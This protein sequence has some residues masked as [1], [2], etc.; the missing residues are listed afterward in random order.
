MACRW[1]AAEGGD[2]NMLRY[3]LEDA[4]R[5]GRACY[6][7]DAVDKR[8]VEVSGDARERQRRDGLGRFADA[9]AVDLDAVEPRAYT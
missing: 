2:Q 1:L 3:A 9:R 4:E 7:Q 5:V 8:R 6:P